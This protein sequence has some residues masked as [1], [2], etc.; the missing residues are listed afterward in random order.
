M[1]RGSEFALTLYAPEEIS[2]FPQRGNLNSE[3]LASPRILGLPQNFNFF[4][5]PEPDEKQFKFHGHSFD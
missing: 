1:F 2:L 4:S 5:N 3:S